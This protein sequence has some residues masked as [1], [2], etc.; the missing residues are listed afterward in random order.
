MEDLMKVLSRMISARIT[1]NIVFAVMIV[2]TVAFT[3]TAMGKDKAVPYP[4]S[5]QKW[6]DG[7]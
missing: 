2:T 4:E 5:L 6:V 7:G 1:C 3:A